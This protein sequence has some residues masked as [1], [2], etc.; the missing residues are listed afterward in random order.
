MNHKNINDK[1]PDITS[2]FILIVKNNYIVILGGGK[3]NE[4]K[5]LIFQGF[6]FF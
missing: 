3:V 6:L 1:F 2:I 5:S 4:K